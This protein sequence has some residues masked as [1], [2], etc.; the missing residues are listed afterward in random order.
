MLHK[1][2]CS[3]AKMVLP[4]PSPSPKEPPEQD[5]HGH[6]R[7]RGCSNIREFEFLGKLGEGTFGLVFFLAIKDWAIA[8]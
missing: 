1:T 5:N 3:L 2:L 6:S 8:N 4:V 7:F